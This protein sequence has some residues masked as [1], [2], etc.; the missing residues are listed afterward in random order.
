MSKNIFRTIVLLIFVI[1]ILSGVLGYYYPTKATLEFYEFYYSV[2]AA[3]ED[4]ILI[5]ATFFVGAILMIGSLIGILLFWRPSR[6]LYIIS[7][8]LLIPSYYI[9]PTFIYSPTS[10]ILYDIGMIGS[11]VILA[12]MF[13]E[14]INSMFNKKSNKAN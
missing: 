4:S 1:A 9:E 10:K 3:T 14:P 5:T 6:W 7:Y 12:A 8:I 11:G 2:H 13:L